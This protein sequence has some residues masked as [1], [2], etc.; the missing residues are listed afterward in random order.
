MSCPRNSPQDLGHDHS[1]IPPFPATNKFVLGGHNPVQGNILRIELPILLQ[2]KLL[3]SYK[4]LCSLHP[5]KIS[6]MALEVG[7]GTFLINVSNNP[8]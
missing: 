3:P 8:V 1:L 5:G 6:G 7:L 2:M 4:L